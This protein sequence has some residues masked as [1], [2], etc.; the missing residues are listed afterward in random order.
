MLQIAVALSYLHGG[1]DFNGT[2]FV[3]RDIKPE[4]VL[5]NTKGVAK[6]TDFGL[7]KSKA[8]S[9]SRSTVVGQAGTLT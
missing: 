6:L 3:H 5:L 1:K 7:A 9:A 8:S 2:T 4:N